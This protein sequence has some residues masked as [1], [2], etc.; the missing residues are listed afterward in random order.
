MQ[1]AWQ[2]TRPLTGERLDSACS[3]TPCHAHDACVPRS[4]QHPGPRPVPLSGSTLA[5]H[6][7]RKPE[8]VGHS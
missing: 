5:E 3:Q 1:P 4:M 2:G 8:L 6:A 7:H